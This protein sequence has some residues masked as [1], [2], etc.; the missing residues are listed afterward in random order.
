MAVRLLLLV[1]GKTVPAVPA[2]GSGQQKPE[3]LLKVSDSAF[4]THNKTSLGDKSPDFM[5]NRIRGDG[6]RFTHTW[7]LPDSPS[8]RLC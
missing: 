3:V 6:I 8:P 7:L 5:C 2:S 1:P 4:Q